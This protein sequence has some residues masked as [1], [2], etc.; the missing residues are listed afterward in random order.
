MRGA[1][2]EGGAAAPPLALSETEADW[3][4]GPAGPRTVE[5][6]CPGPWAVSSSPWWLTAGADGHTLTLAPRLAG[7]MRGAVTVSA[8]G[9]EARIAVAAPAA[10]GWDGAVALRALGGVAAGTVA[11]ALLLPLFPES[12]STVSADPPLLMRL[13]TRGALAGAAV[14]AML[15]GARLAARS[16]L[17]L[18]VG[19]VAMVPALLFGIS[20][21]MGVLPPL[22][23]STDAFRTEVRTVFVGGTSFAA[24]GAG[25]A[26]GLLG[27]HTAWGGA[28][29][30][31]LA[32]LAGV[33][34]VRL[35]ARLEGMREGLSLR[36]SPDFI[37][38]PMALLALLLLA[39]HALVREA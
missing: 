21:A 19:M 25:W 33:G 38:Y 18:A 26:A 20:V 29:R 11:A 14:G 2:D 22:P 7:P 36:W 1:P 32:G 12:A 23:G 13:A 15:G 30:G 16:A 4:S 39:R 3:V 8:G 17:G 35:M 10:R 34:L 9:E 37:V 5:V 6:Y 24:V 31:F 27:L 28:W